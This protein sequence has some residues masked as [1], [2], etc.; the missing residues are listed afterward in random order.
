MR[1]AAF[2]AGSLIATNAFGAEPPSPQACI[3]ANERSITLRNEHHL[4]AARDELVVCA[5]EACPALVR[6][7]C[8]RHIDEVVAA[9]PSIV[10][11]VRDASGKDLVAVAVSMDGAR[12]TDRL[13]GTAIALDPGE[14]T[15]KFETAGLDPVVQTIVVREA[16][17]GQHVSVTMRGQTSVLPIVGVATIVVGVLGVGVGAFFGWRA[18]SLHDDVTA[19]CPAYPACGI[20]SANADNATSQTAALLSTIGFVAGGLLVATGIALFWPPNRQRLPRASPPMAFCCKVRFDA[21]FCG[22]RRVD[23]LGTV[24]RVCVDSRHRRHCRADGF[25]ANR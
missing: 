3:A 20:E 5:A 8:L 16:V 9:I 19:A 7:E 22:R 13:D 17:Q 10:F 2:V 25:R 14:R 18:K 24:S 11:D 4:R 12:L 23:S 15:F 6:A 21:R 1:S